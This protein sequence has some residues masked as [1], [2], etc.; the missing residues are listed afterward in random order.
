MSLFHSCST[1]APTLPPTAAGTFPLTV[2]T[3]LATNIINGQ[4]GGATL[5]GQLEGFPASI[6]TYFY[7]YSIDSSLQTGVI[8]TANQTLTATGGVDPI[9]PTAV[10]G[11]T[12]GTYYYQVYAIDPVT[13]QVIP[14]GIVSFVISATDFPTRRPTLAPTQPAVLTLPATNMVNGQSGVANLNGQVSLPNSAGSTVTYW[15]K[16]STDSTLQTGVQMT[17]NNTLTASGG[18]DPTASTPVTGLAAGKPAHPHSC[19][20][21]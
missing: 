14:G 19:K 13:G 21:R 9:N 1:A 11:L 17:A 12:P 20:Y 16:Y 7:K 2:V 15:Y 18:T 4:S 5:N 3:D 6:V 8:T 10:S